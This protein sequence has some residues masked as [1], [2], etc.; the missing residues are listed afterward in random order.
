MKTENKIF[1]QELGKSQIENLVKEVKETMATDMPLINNK[2]AFTLVDLWNLERNRK[3]R[4]VRRP[5]A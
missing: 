5:F 3:K 4:I 1:F 2:T